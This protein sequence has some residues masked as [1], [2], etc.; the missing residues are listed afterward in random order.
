MRYQTL[1]ILTLFAAVACQPKETKK[2]MGTIERLDPA[3]DAIVSATAQPE[4]IAEGFEWSEGPC[5]I[6]STKTLIWSDV[7][8]DTIFQWSEEKGT[9][10]Y[11]TP[12][13]YTGTIPRGGEM[14]SNGLT[15]TKDG[16][17]VLCQHGDRRIAIMDA[18]LN[19]PEPKYITVVDNIDGKKFSSPNDAV[20]RSNGDIFFTDP[21]YGLPNGVNDSTKETS[22]N[23]VYK[24]SQGKATLLVDS[25]TRPNGIAFLPGE[26]TFIV[27]NSDHEKA[28]WYAFDLTEDDSVTNARVFYDATKESKAGE[29]GLPDGFRVD[30]NGNIFASGP[31]GIW[32][33]SREG[34]VLGKIKLTEPASNCALSDDEKT[35]FI[36]NDMYILRVKLRD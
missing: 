25:L 24:A 28:I 2:T 18:P 31:G 34:K 23:G 11:L 4:I 13:G 1:G 16:K 12:S 10:V 15:L 27:A 3:L 14:G 30:K 17:L 6:E 26:K 29:K 35:L 20:V 5:W 22:F 19:K 7:P 9:S 21:P 32:I 8:R 36:T 33:F